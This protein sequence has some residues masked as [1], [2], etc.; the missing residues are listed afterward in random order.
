MAKAGDHTFHL[1]QVTSPQVASRGVGTCVAELRLEPS[2][3]TA[4]F[5]LFLYSDLLSVYLLRSAI[6]P[7]FRPSSTSPSALPTPT[8]PENG[9][10]ARGSRLDV[11]LDLDQAFARSSHLSRRLQPN[12][13]PFLFPTSDR[14]SVLLIL[15][16]PVF[17]P[18]TVVPFGT[19]PSSSNPAP[20]H[21][22]RTSRPRG[23]QDDGRGSF[24]LTG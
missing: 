22:T 16:A 13:P 1:R 8:S 4:V 23:E 15:S 6:D 7:L 9:S 24:C 20:P 18:K 11:S 2:Q 21:R 3:S 5:I 19:P 14:H 12:P 17:T 10:T